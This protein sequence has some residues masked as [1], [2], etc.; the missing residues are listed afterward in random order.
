MRIIKFRA[1]EILLGYW[2]YAPNVWCGSGRVNTDGNLSHVI[3]DNTNCQ[4]ETLG[5]FVGL[6]DGNG[7]EVYEG[8]IIR[9]PQEE[10]YHAEIIGVVEYDTNSFILRSFLSGTAS[11][12]GWVLRKRNSAIKAE[13]IGNIFDNPELIKQTTSK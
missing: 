11:D 4:K 3:L 13:V 6:Y 2:V 9:I 7:K 8:D 5:Q 12:L 1:K 10:F